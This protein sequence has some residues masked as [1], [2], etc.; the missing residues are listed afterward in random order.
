M[1]AKATF[2]KEN[3]TYVQQKIEEIVKFG[4]R[5]KLAKSPNIAVLKHL[6]INF[7][8]FCEVIDL[9]EG[10]C[11][12]SNL[13]TQGYLQIPPLL[14]LG[15]PGIGKTAFV[16]ELSR[17]IGVNFSRIDIGIS[18]TSAILAG[19]SLTWGSGRCGEI[20]NLLS[21]SEYMNPIIILDE[22]DKAAGNYA[23]PVEPILLALLESE[24]SKTF[25][26]EAILM[27]LNASNIIWVGT[28]NYLEQISEPILSRFTVFEI[29]SPDLAQSKKI[30]QN[31]YRNFKTDNNWGAN[32][33]DDLDEESVLKL[34]EF[35][36]RVAS[37]LLQKAFGIAA[38][39]SRNKI[40]ADDICISKNKKNHTIGFV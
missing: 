38:I 24:S 14:L 20:F 25:R 7:P 32:F 19:L 30:V 34:S 11:A 6:R 31:I 21:E 12:L 3:A 18:S 10:A 13:A 40:I 37:K 33:D 15:P 29:K 26:D 22:I 39:N 23:M 4:N 28:A 17:L 27:E 36:P 9:V 16:Q 35:T 1:Q 8:N 2:G 5:R